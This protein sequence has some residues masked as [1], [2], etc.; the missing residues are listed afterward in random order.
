MKLT[1]NILS[2]FLVMATMFLQPMT[3]LMGQEDSSYALTS[4][5]I[6]LNANG[7][8]INGNA[9]E[10]IRAT[11]GDNLDLIADYTPVN[12]GYQFSGWVDGDNNIYSAMYIVPS[13]NIT[14]IAIWTPLTPTTYT[15]TYDGNGHTSGIVPTDQTQ[16]ETGDIATVLTGEPIKTGY[17]F[18][19]W[20]HTIRTRTSSPIYTSGDTFIIESADV[21]LVA[22][23]IRLT[24]VTYTVTYDGNGHTGGIIPIDTNNYQATHTVTVLTDEPTKTG[25]KFIGW[26]HASNV[27]TAN[28]TFQM[29]AEHITLTAIW[30][31]DATIPEEEDD[32]DEGSKETE[33]E[34]TPETADLANTGTHTTEI[35]TISSIIL[36]FLTSTLIVLTKKR[37]K[38]K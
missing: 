5:T 18:T 23:W 3:M 20:A 2:V 25:Y 29:P 27:F 6:T 30:E 16:Y 17:T 19:G 38:Q 9:I 7:G 34:K 35:I 24:P 12:A 37:I 14:F 8:T 13:N 28:D 33:A 1:R 26:S 10:T 15:V 4:Q 22:T 11:I 32:I 21:T 36:T 31:A